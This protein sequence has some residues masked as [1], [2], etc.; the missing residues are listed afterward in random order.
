MNNTLKTIVWI[1]AAI[2]VVSLG[3]AAVLFFATGMVGPW[4]SGNGISV[5]EQRSFA[6]NGFDKIEVRTSST[7]VHIT[8][9]D[10]DT[11]D[12]WQRGTVYTGQADSIPAL[13]AEQ[14]GE[15]LEI[16]TE[17]K[18]G[19][20]WVLGFFSSDL[21]LEIKVPQHYRGALVVDTSSGDVEISNQILSELSVETSSGDIRLSFVQA[22]TIEM[23]SSSGD[24]T[25][26]GITAESS[27][28]TSSSGEI[29]VRDLYGGARAKSSSGDIT[30]RYR[31]F[32][33]DLEVRSSSGDVGLYLT[34]SAQF[35]MEARASSGN[36]D[37]AFP[38]TLNE[39]NSEIRRNRL[40]GTVGEGAHKVVVQ[41][42]SGDITI[43]P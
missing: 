3:I 5:D 16:T 23:E 21:I 19:R 38:V 20:K 31:K 30:L 7:D 13:A 29:Q 32:N 39:A 1:T 37:C 11:V 22:A 2:A 9:G 28:L 18:D 14:S 12:I 10:G 33:A 35:R 15:V 36:I 42:S 40:F 41:T 27:S 4:K 8:A 25:V 17:R 26:D 34:E 24:Q 6:L 43:R